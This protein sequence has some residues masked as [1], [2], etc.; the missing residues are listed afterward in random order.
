MTTAE[1]MREGAV[2]RYGDGLGDSSKRPDDANSVMLNLG[3][4]DYNE[5]AE[6]DA[7]REWLRLLAAIASIIM[8]AVAVYPIHLG[9]ECY[10][11]LNEDVKIDLAQCKNILNIEIS[12]TLLISAAVMEVIM[13]TLFFYSCRH[14]FC[15]VKRKYTS[16]LLCCGG[17]SR[18]VSPVTYPLSHSKRVQ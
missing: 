5:E 7:C 12:M 2:G 18:S 11:D 3:P 14:E 13:L 6:Y 4:A 17:R 1:E 10:L 9:V 15:G 8:A 16:G